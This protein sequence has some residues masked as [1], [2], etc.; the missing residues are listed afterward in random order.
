MDQ[1]QEKSHFWRVSQ[2][3]DVELL[4][5]SYSRFSFDKH[6]HEEYALGVVETGIHAFWYR[7][8]YFKA[9]PGSIVTCQPG[10][11]HNGHAG[12]EDVWRYRMFYIA[13]EYI[14]QLC[15]TYQTPLNTL[16][17]LNRTVV[18]DADLAAGLWRL[19]RE[20]EAQSLTLERQVLLNQ[21]LTRFL[22]RYSDAHLQIPQCD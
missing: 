21:V 8:A 22:F 13:P 9:V 17:F 14:Q 11:I 19:H 5:A 16:P 2:I 4:H 7:G 3:D 12:S 10:E 20:F 6:F 1:S 15:E 18:E